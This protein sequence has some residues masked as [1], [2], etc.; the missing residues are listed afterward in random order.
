MSASPTR[1]G[2]AAL[3][4]NADVPRASAIAQAWASIGEAVA[5]LSN[6]SGRPLARTIKLI[7]DPLVVRPVQH[8]HLAGLVLTPDAAAE[9]A[10][11]ITRASADLAATAA[12]FLVLKRTRRALRITEGNPQEK[13]FQRCFELARA[14]GM[15]EPESAETIAVETVSEIAASG[16]D[17]LLVRVREVL[18]D[19][20]AAER[21]HAALVAAW[22]GLPVPAPGATAEDAAAPSAALDAC[23]T[24]VPPDLRPLLADGAGTAASATLGIPGAAA[25][26]G[27]TMRDLPSPPELGL[28]AS[29]RDLPRPFDRSIFERLFAVLAGGAA[30]EIERDADVLLS[31]E[32]ARSASP[33]ELADESSRVVVL[34][35]VEASHALEPTEL[36]RPTNAH[37]LLS[38][39]W[40]RE[41]Y[42][43]RALRL[44]A[45]ANGVPEPIREDIRTVRQGYLRRLWARLHGRELRGQETSGAELWD[46]LDGVLRSVIMDQRHRLKLAIGRGLEGAA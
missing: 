18:S 41:A 32:I 43:R 24:S 1:A 8:P 39:R 35:G 33:W 28:S 3:A 34:L 40:Q 11:R 42:V 20:L 10:E 21:L 38:A 7:I 36:L 27:L 19:P 2:T 45:G 13:Y 16:G 29:K 31:E 46:T 26:L 12:W 22:R 14:H 25:G 15:P 30:H 9:L 4:A 5:P 44:P 37:R 23:G 17:S 6:G